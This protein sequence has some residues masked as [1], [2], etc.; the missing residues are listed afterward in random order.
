MHTSALSR[1]LLFTAT[2]AVVLALLVCGVLVW[3]QS[4]PARWIC[5]SRATTF[6]SG[7]QL[8]VLC[9][10]GG[11]PSGLRLAARLRAVSPNT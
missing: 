2:I 6:D 1:A 8:Y 5:L 4:E 3:I 7:V 9:S 10:A 11:I